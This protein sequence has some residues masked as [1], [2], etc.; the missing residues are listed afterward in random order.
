[1]SEEIARKLKAARERLGLSQSQAAKKWSVPLITLQSWEQNVRTPRGL[2][3]K[4]L[5]ELLD[6][7]L[8]APKKSK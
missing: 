5:N 4:A 7:I 6:G 2:A 3:L 1:M 8:G